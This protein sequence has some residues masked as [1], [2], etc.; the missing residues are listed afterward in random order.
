[1]AAV[2]ITGQRSGAALR[3]RWELCSC[4]RPLWELVFSVRCQR[5]LRT[6]LM[7][8]SEARGFPSVGLTVGFAT[9]A[10]GGHWGGEAGR[11]LHASF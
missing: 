3:G 11:A 10:V 4:A 1:M 5:F 7:R 8:E 2:V 9:A 6:E